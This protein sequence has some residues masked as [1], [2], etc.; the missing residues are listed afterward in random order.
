MVHSDAQ[1]DNTYQTCPL[2][3]EYTIAPCIACSAV[4]ADDMP[5]DEVLIMFDKLEDITE[6]M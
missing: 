3:G 5:L 6:W 4:Y 1:S 2:C